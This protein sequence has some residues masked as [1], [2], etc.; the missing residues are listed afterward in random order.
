M[1]SPN[2]TDLS[3]DQLAG[4]EVVAVFPVRSFQSGK[5]R[6]SSIISQEARNQTIKHL[7]VR[8]LAV[9]RRLP[10]I[11]CLVV[12]SDQEVVDWSISG[13]ALALLLE[14]GGLNP[15]LDDMKQ[16]LACQDVSNMLVVLPDL[17][18]LNYDDLTH[19]LTTRKACHVAIAP[20]RHGSGTNALMLNPATPFPFLFG[21]QSYHRYRTA[22]Q[23]R[24][25]TMLSCSSQGWGFDLDTPEDWQLLEVLDPTWSRVILG[26]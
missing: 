16:F 11:V 18:L 25:L 19:L 24:S 21:E 7:V 10:S 17:P 26:H 2:P 22:A 23:T 4:K 15:T 9:F 3:L 8:T 6:L 14:A 12:S 1:R 5:Q 20:D 13:G